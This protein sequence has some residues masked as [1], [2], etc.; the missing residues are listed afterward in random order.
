M[1]IYAHTHTH[2]C[3]YIYVHTHVGIYMS[4]YRYIHIYTH[5]YNCAFI[6]LKG[7]KVS[8]LHDMQKKSTPQLGELL[9]PV[10]KL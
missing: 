1:H 3:V 2:I 9:G 7:S 6:W 10:R 5:T 8:Y 4:I